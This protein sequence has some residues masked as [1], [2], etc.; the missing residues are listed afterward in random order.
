MHVYFVLIY[1]AQTCSIL[2]SFEVVFRVSVDKCKHILREV[3]Q[4]KTSI[5]KNADIL[6]AYL[7]DGWLFVKI[8]QISLSTRW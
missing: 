1:R 4:D 6:S 5:K 8:I 3:T 7:I 2:T